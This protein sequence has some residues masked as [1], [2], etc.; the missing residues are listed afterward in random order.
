MVKFCSKLLIVLNSRV[1][2][3]YNRAKLSK[4]A[5]Q[6]P[7]NF[8]DI[9]N[10]VTKT[11]RQITRK[12]K[13]KLQIQEI[14]SINLNAFWP[15]LLKTLLQSVNRYVQHKC[16]G[17]GNFIYVWPTKRPV[18]AERSIGAWFR[19]LFDMKWSTHVGVTLRSYASLSICY[20]CEK[21]IFNLLTPCIAPLRASLCICVGA[22]FN[23]MSLWLVS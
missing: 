19:I 3:Y 4:L 11:N 2:N 18:R 8:D 7:I 20:A 15:S 21:G 1:L 22:K 9:L 6:I 23:A 17:S 10:L 14:D 13:K 16:E 12:K 5:L